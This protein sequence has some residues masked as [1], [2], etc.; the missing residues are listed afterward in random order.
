[1]PLCL[2]NPEPPSLFALEVTRSGLALLRVAI[3][4][5]SLPV[6]PRMAR[7]AVCD[8]AVRSCRGA[9]VVPGTTAVEMSAGIHVRTRGADADGVI[10]VQASLAAAGV[11]F[12]LGHRDGGLLAVVMLGAQRR[13]EIDCVGPDVEGVNERNHPL[14]DRSCIAVMTVAQDTKGNSQAQFD[15]DEEKL[16]VERT[17]EK[18]AIT[19]VDSKALVLDA[20]KNRRDDVTTNEQA[21]EYIVQSW[22][23]FRVEDGEEDQ[24]SG[25]N[26]GRNSCDD[27]ANLLPQRR[28]RVQAPTMA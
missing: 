21:E 6:N 14:D 25:A 11:V 2:Y 15:E 1:M 16:H 9:R 17:A 18:L 5:V 12:S 20:N 19:V 22:V 8:M 23:P 28:V 24:S 3:G 7:V 10:L 4:V 27:G 26:D 13:E